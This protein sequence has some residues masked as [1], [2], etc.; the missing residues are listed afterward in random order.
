[1]EA[2][3]DTATEV[4]VLPPTARFPGVD[5]GCVSGHAPVV[6]RTVASDELFSAASVAEMP[7]VYVVSQ[8]NP[9]NVKLVVGV[10][11]QLV[12]PTYARYVA[13]SRLSDEGR[14]LT[15]TEVAEPLVTARP[16]GVE[17]GSTSFRK[18]V[19]S[20]FDVV[21]PTQTVAELW[22]HSRLQ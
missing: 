1:V 22:S 8:V 9:S 15:E 13:T 20:R 14:Q 18:T 21:L 10:D 4:I 2:L 11:P 12:L 17:G 19:T 5:G 7:S 16:V 3:H 6:A